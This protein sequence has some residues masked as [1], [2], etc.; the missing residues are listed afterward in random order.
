MT[1]AGDLN[2]RVHCQR[3]SNIIDSYGK[4]I[5]GGPFETIFTVA[6]EMKPL[7]G[8]EAVM[9]NRLAGRQPYIV[10]LRNSS[11]S[12][13]ITSDWQ[14]VDKRNPSRVFAVKS[15]PADPDGTRQWLDIMVMEGAPS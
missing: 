13:K 5:P 3:R 12:R 10:R 8:S 9:A 7:R 2:Q 4:E 1:G 6:A 14:L 15:P 11:Q